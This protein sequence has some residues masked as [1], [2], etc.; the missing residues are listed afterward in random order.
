MPGCF[1]V[2]WGGGMKRIGNWNIT[3]EAATLIETKKTMEW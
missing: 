3:R 2:I 1:L